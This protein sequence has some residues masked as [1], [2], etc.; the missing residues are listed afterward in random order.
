MVDLCRNPHSK[1]AQVLIKWYPL[2]KVK[3]VENKL[4]L[5]SRRHAD[6]M[7]DSNA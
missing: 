2:S 4:V 5:A 7:V 6:L 1:H 3:V